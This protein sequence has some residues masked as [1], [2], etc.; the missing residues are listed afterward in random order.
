MFARLGQVGCFNAKRVIRDKAIQP[1]HAVAVLQ[2]SFTQ[3]RAYEARCSGHQ[4]FHGSAPLTSPSTLTPRPVVANA[5]RQDQAS[6]STRPA[7]ALP[8]T[9]VDCMPSAA[10]TARRHT[11]F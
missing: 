4:A 10:A 7:L 1:H 11:L 3:V 6:H 9:T 8:P 5:A 2:Q